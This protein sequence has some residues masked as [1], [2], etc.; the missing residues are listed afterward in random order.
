VISG[1]RM[2]SVRGTFMYKYCIKAVLSE[3][4]AV[5][6]SRKLCSVHPGLKVRHSSQLRTIE[7]VEGSSTLHESVSQLMRSKSRSP[8]RS[9]TV[10][11]STF[12]S[13]RPGQQGELSN[14]SSTIKSPFSSAISASVMTRLR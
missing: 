3:Y 13:Q 11:G 8:E 7:D 12:S 10:D 2:W 9:R 4:R 14:Q 1:W 6:D 5:A